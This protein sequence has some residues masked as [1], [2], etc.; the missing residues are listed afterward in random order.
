VI[1]NVIVKLSECPLSGSVVDVPAA[2]KAWVASVNASGGI[3][4]HKIELFTKDD[5]SNPTT[6]V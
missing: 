3:N 1:E 4:G 5:A 6:S 2:Y